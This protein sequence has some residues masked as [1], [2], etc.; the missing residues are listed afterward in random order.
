M[1]WEEF[2]QYVE[3]Q[4]VTDDM[5]ISYINV[6]GLCGEV[7]RVDIHKDSSFSVD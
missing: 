2:K 1:T 3:D 6:P 4:G 7:Q 5:E